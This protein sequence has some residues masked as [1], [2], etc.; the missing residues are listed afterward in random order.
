MELAVESAKE[1][2]AKAQERQAIAANRKRREIDWD[3]G[4]Y[5]FLDTSNLK[6]L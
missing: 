5:V 4:D 3:V 6:L 2:M 1:S